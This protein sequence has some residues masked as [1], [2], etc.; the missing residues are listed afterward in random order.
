MC[1]TITAPLRCRTLGDCPSFDEGCSF[2]FWVLGYLVLGIPS[3]ILFLIVIISS[4][5]KH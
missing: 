4:I 5:K 3:W 2:G 1:G